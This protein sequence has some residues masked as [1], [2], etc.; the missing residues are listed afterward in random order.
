MR[1]AIC[2]GSFDPIT[3]GHLDIISRAARLFDHVEVAVLQNSSKKCVF[4]VDE[5]VDMIRD[6]IKELPNVSASSFDG[7]L[8]D[9]ARK[10]GATAIVKGLRAVSDFDYE[11]QMALF[12]KEINA[13]V[14]TIFLT[15]SPEHMYLSSS[16][17]REMAAHGGDM[18]RFVPA[19]VE[20]KI[21]V[22]YNEGVAQ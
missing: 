20:N 22:K 17:V 10:I 7:L 12:N 2:P 9:Y 14:E 8:V 5:R 6:C 15:T 16:V 3:N 19:C 4:T 11:F 21:K 13:E 18:S 1:I